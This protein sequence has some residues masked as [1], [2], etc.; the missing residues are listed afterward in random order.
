MPRENAAMKRLGM[1]VFKPSRRPHSWVAKWRDPVTGRIRQRTLDAKL[2]RDAFTK[3]SDL[4]QRIVAGVSIEDVDW[5]DY[6]EK[7]E[8]DHLADL[9]DA[10]REAWKTTRNHINGFGAPLHLEDVTA[11]WVAAWQTYLRDTKMARN[12]VAFYSRYLRAAL[13]QARDWDLVARVPKIRVKVK[14]NA[15]ADAVTPDELKLILAAVPEVRSKDT[16]IWDRLLRGL[17]RCNLRINDLR[18]LSWDKNSPIWL[19]TREIFPLIRIQPGAGKSEEPKIQLILESFWGVCCETPQKDRTGWVF[20]IPNGRGGQMSR[21]RTIRIIS[22]IGEKAGLDHGTSHNIGRRAF[23]PQIDGALTQ[24]E[25]H[26]A[27]GHGDFNTTTTYYDT[28]NALEIAAKLW[29][30]GK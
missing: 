21:K 19:D 8:R 30:K 25:A 24:A 29:G 15:R 27:M 5:E 2:K 3:A 26:K 23:F 10:H 12:S 1:S 22:E 16:A 9:S 18:R 6:C 28:R 13:N 17:A 20:P 4:A 7:Y 11:A 14:K